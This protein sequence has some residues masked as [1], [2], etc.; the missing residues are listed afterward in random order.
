MTRTTR[1]GTGSPLT[2]GDDSTLRWAIVLRECGFTPWLAL[3]FTTYR[4]YHRFAQSVP[5]NFAQRGGPHHPRP[6]KDDCAV[7]RGEAG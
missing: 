4:A 6:R 3:L 2:S 5:A 7:C 1:C